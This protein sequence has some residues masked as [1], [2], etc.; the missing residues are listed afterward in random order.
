MSRQRIIL[1][2]TALMLG[3]FMSS[4]EVTVVSTA[5]PTIA[6]ELGGLALYSWVF[7]AYMVTSTTTIPIYG[8]LSDLYG[9]RP[10]YATALL[11]FLGGSILCGQAQSMLQLVIFRAVQGLGAGGVM[12]LTFVIIGAMFSL[13]QR[14]K[15][16]GY[17]ASI[18]GLSSVVGPLLGGFLVDQVSW[19]WIFY[20]N[21]LPGLLALLLFWVNW[22][23]PERDV[24]TGKVTIDYAGAVLLTMTIVLLL[25][26]LMNIRNPMGW[27]LLAATVVALLLLLWVERRATD[28]VLPLAFFRQRAFTV[29]CLHGLFAGA[30]M[31][32]SL[33]YVPLFI[34]VAFNTSATAAG[35]ALTPM[36]FGWVL[37][38][39]IGGRIMMRIGYFTLVIAGCVMLTLGTLLLSQMGDH[40]SRIFVLTS[41]A[42]MGIGMG[43]AIPA[44]LIIVQSTAQ[45]S[46]LGVATSTLQFT[47]TVGG[48]IGVSIMGVVLSSGLASQLT[49]AGLDPA[50]IS[51]ESLLDRTNSAAVSSL[52]DTVRAALAGATQGIFAVALLAAFLAL[53]ATL[54]TPRGL[55]AQA[56][57]Q[58]VGAK[59]APRPAEIPH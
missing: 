55:L 40:A 48:I 6:A 58:V 30:A 14:A 29:A 19:P 34:Q 53:I 1:V 23:E 43:L 38:S 2:T 46:M 8:K 45:R 25:V 11:I 17:F 26:G 5:M 33:S 9:R 13:E 28:P 31:F 44:F 20:V 27:G 36:I 59:A 10:V 49:A 47:R 18:W 16:Q 39:I 50:T 7:S 15:M 4:M 52:G 21:V 41:L 56:G 54:F 57:A 24:K 3:L 32:G 35:A 22:R 42:S 51:V 12:P 37:A